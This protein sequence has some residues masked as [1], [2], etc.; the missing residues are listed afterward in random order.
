MIPNHLTR[1]RNLISRILYHVINLFIYFQD[2]I[3]DYQSRLTDFFMY[4]QKCTVFFM[5]IFFISA[6]GAKS[7]MKAP[8]SHLSSPQE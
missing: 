2:Y 7:S 8:I 1:Q 4:V 3:S 6:K 5:P